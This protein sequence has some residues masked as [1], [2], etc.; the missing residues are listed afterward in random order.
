MIKYL[1]EIKPDGVY[2][3]TAFNMLILEI[4]KSIVNCIE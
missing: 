1:Y 4:Y 2:V 3:I